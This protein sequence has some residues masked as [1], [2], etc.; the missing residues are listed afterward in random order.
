MKKFLALAVFLLNLL[1]LTE[2]SAQ[3]YSSETELVALLN[4]IVADAMHSEA[5]I[6]TIVT[7]ESEYEFND[8]SEYGDFSQEV[9]FSDGTN[10]L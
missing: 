8:Y 3:N 6:Y 4:K 2:V 5:E 9:V 7:G 10:Y 1:S